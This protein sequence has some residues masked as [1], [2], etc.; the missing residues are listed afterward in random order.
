VDWV[1]V[2]SKLLS[3]VAYSG[4]WHQLYLKFRSGDIYCYRE[5]PLWRFEELLA[6]DSKA[7][8]CRLHILNRYS[9]ERV[10]TAVA[11]AI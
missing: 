3:A 10:H 11:A 1:P 5:V 6:T 8:Y 2:R 7:K 4:D 9:H